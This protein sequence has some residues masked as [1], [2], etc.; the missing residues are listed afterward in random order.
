MR[1]AERVHACVCVCMHACVRVHVYGYIN[2]GQL[3][4]APP[5]P[6][7]LAVHNA[8]QDHSHPS[9]CWSSGRISAGGKVSKMG[10]VPERTVRGGGSW[11]GG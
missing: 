2:L 11:G 3:A 5:L 4:E 8:K 7:R 6:F 10:G 1:G 9:H